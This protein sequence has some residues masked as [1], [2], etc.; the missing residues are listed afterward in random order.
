MSDATQT[1]RRRPPSAERYIWLGWLVG[2]LL[3]AAAWKLVSDNTIWAFAADAP[4]AGWDMISRMWPPRWHYASAILQPLW[5]TLNIATLGTALGTVIAVPVA[6]LAARNTSPVPWLLRPLALGI[7]VA[8]RSINSLIWALLLVTVVGPGVLAGIIAIALRSIGFI[9]K[10][11]YEAIEEIDTRQVEAVTATGATTA[12]V[13]SY[14]IVPQILPSLVGTTVYRWDINIREST[15]L[16]IVGAGGIG[17]P[18]AASVDTL[19]WPQVTVIFAAIL[20]TVFFAEWL[21]NRIRRVLI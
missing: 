13:V 1:W 8:S 7:I 18:L 4:A 10:L 11:L 16:G 9:G 15:V 6:F 19:A 17:L 14:A 5:D 3:F 12:Q 2:A 20:L 21:S